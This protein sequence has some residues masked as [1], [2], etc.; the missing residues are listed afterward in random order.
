MMKH[1][2]FISYRREGGDLFAKYLY[3]RLVR[4][5]YGVSYD[6]DTL[7]SGPFNNL[8]RERVNECTDFI[9]V[10]S[11]GCFDKVLDPSVSPEDDWMRCEIREAL[12]QKKNVITVMLKGFDWPEKL[13]EDIDRVRFMNGP[14]YNVEYIDAYYD[15]LKKRFLQTKAHLGN[16]VK[17]LSESSLGLPTIMLKGNSRFVG[18]EVELRQL[19]ELC[20]NGRIPLIHAAGGTG[21]TELAIEYGRRH[22]SDIYCGGVFYVP[23]EA[24]SDWGVV[25]RNLYRKNRSFFRR[26][27]KD[28]EDEGKSVNEELSPEQIRDRL[29]MLVANRDFLL[30]L[31]NVDREGLGLFHDD[32]SDGGVAALFDGDIPTYCHII[33]T[34]RVVDG[35]LPSEMTTLFPLENL[36]MEAA[37]ELMERI[38]P[39]TSESEKDAV[40]QIADLLQCHAWS[41]EL[42][43]SDVA[44]NNNDRRHRHD[45][46]YEKKLA[47]LL[48]DDSCPAGAMGKPYRMVERT[49]EALFRPT[50]DSLCANEVHGESYLKLAKIV[51]LFGAED[52]EW[53]VL[54]HLWDTLFKG[55]GEFAEAMSVLRDYSIVKLNYDP[56]AESGANITPIVMHRFVG[57]VLRGHIALDAAVAEVGRVLVEYLG[58]D[59]ADWIRLLRHTPAFSTCCQF[60]LLLG[61]NWVELLITNPEFADRCEWTKLN[62]GDWCVLLKARHQFIDKFVSECDLRKLSR[63]E[64][65]RLIAACPQ[66]VSLCDWSSL[67]CDFWDLL[68]LGLSDL[69]EYVQLKFTGSDWVQFLLHQPDL[70][71]RCDWSLLDNDDWLEL[72]SE[73]PQFAERCPWKRFR[74]DDWARLLSKCPY[75]ADVCNFLM[76]SGA[77][78]ATLLSVQPQF[79]GKCEWKK[80]D[81]GAWIRLLSRQPQFCERFQ[82]Q[83]LTGSQW[84][85]LLLACPSVYE[86]CEWSKLNG[87]DL[88]ELLTAQPKFAEYCD[89]RRLNGSQWVALLSVQPQFANQCEWGLLN[90]ERWVELLL[91]QPQLSDRCK[92]M[93]W[94]GDLCVKLLSARPQFAGLCEWGGLSGWDWARLLVA[95]PQ[96]AGNCPWKMLTGRDW[97]ELL[98]ERPQFS[99]EC[100]WASLGTWDWVY[101]LSVR[102]QFVNKCEWRNFEGDAW[103]QL[104]REQPQ[105]ARWC[106]FDLLTGE[107]WRKLLI[108]QP[109]FSRLCDWG[110]LNDMDWSELLAVHPNFFKKCKMEHFSDWAW[111]ELLRLQPQFGRCYIRDFDWERLNG[112]DWAE[113]LAK[114]PQYAERC[115]WGKLGDVDWFEL[116]KKRPEFSGKYDWMRSCQGKSESTNERKWLALGGAQWAELLR[117]QP[118]FADRCEWERIGGEDWL[119]LLKARPEFADR[120]DWSK[121]DQHTLHWL[122]NAQ[123]QFSRQFYDYYKINKG[124]KMDGWCWVQLLQKN[125]ELVNDCEWEKLWESNWEELLK[126]RPRFVD[127]CEWSKFRGSDWV[128]LL[129]KYPE[130]SDRCD[131]RRLDGSDWSKLLRMAPQFRFVYFR[132][133]LILDVFYWL[134]LGVVMMLIFCWEIV[135]MPVVWA[136]RE[137]KRILSAS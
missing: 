107:A 137:F 84:V 131:W 116:I 75:Y 13:P 106:D 30:I 129:S 70:A 110:K 100:N 123:P 128:H 24:V 23:M 29:L 89:L 57:S 105:C 21:K 72:L 6:I 44:M 95:Q 26:A 120:C 126:E 114:H 91:A 31:D 39:A 115:D 19:H 88:V 62:G 25:L 63:I 37:V 109:Q 77:D 55:E 42:A 28:D 5:G 121:F 43:A 125:P 41:I 7:P 4:D 1:D 135:W 82:P 17:D 61:K 14:T 69:D 73:R 53:H 50:I 48:K 52:A 87:E 35:F 66:L 111:V 8:L 83:K 67:E 85:H 101:L 36:P 118:Q 46:T 99:K 3:D 108:A 96:F 45:L 2:I 68:S 136:Y 54:R 20:M 60:D 130:F 94:S 59:C 104:L 15:R 51:S 34:S 90:R 10:L 112:R 33:V 56:Y 119:K 65:R 97:C 47:T 80:I 9:L 38:A 40:R 78:W 103:V 64:R 16:E 32:R 27:D 71:S 132:K 18:R 124:A 12:S 98:S 49:P 92:V 81:D 22:A 133:R 127:Y 122:I 79:A 11:K 113:I 117:C 102:P 86:E 58:F 74:G 76:L 93:K 134:V